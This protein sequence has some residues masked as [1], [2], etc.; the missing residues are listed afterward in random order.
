MKLG[1]AARRGVRLS[2]VLLTRGGL[3][4]LVRWH[5]FSISSFRLVRGLLLEGLD[6]STIIDVGANQ[7]Q[8]ARAA[9]E[10]Y[11]GAAVM[12]F[13]PLP[14]AASAFRKHLSDR[15][16]VTLVESAVGSTSGSATL[17][18]QSYSLASSLLQPIDPEKAPEP[19][20]VPLTRLDRVPKLQ[21]GI[22]RP[23]LLKLDVQGF[24]LEA[25]IGAEEILDQIDAILVETAFTQAYQG[26]PLFTTIYDFLSD[27]G[28]RFVRPL[29]TLVDHRGS[30]VE[31]DAL[32]VRVPAGPV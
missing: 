9:V 8:F 24:E 2:S 7:G 28:W 4:A 22:R 29:D 5:P 20:T 26:A 14:Q 6:F 15:P 25:L 32:F 17:Y 12:S 19:L 16:A 21:E 27:R 18:S 1:P 11:P 10:S 31:M 3:R 23:C 13:E 30:I